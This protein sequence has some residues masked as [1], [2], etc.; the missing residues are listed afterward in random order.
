MGTTNGLL[1]ATPLEGHMLCNF[2]PVQLTNSSEGFETRTA[3]CLL[4]LISPNT[5]GSFRGRKDLNNTCSGKESLRKFAEA[6]LLIF[7]L[8][9]INGKSRTKSS[10]N[11]VLQAQ[12]NQQS[13][14]KGYIDELGYLTHGEEMY[15]E[16]R[17]HSLL[18]L[19]LH[20]HG[21]CKNHT[22]YRL[23]PLSWKNSSTSIKNKR[24]T[25]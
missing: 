25:N 24:D 21:S 19:L 18:T 22:C 20:W 6:N 1:Q 4:S 5:Q 15:R 7:F 23:Y 2:S 13:E 9:W 17:F 10:S 8:K 3:A 14:A 12:C 16:I 11:S